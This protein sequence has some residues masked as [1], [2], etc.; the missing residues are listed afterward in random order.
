MKN[1]DDGFGDDSRDLN[2]NKVPIPELQLDIPFNSRQDEPMVLLYS[3]V[4]QLGFLHGSPAR[5][6][7][8]SIE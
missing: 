6:S 7:K 3:F 4:S 8:C 1:S 2:G 5:T